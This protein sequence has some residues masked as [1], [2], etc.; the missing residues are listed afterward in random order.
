MPSCLLSLGL[1]CR[2]RGTETPQSLELCPPVSSACAASLHALCLGSGLSTTHPDDSN[3]PTPGASASSTFASQ[4]I[5]PN[6]H[7]PSTNCQGDLLKM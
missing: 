1:F 7:H 5:I 6:P 3:H 4:F 2:L